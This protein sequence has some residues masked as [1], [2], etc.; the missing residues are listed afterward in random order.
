MSATA[1]TIPHNETSEAKKVR[2]AGA[3]EA[4]GKVLWPDAKGNY[5]PESL[6][7]PEDKIEDEM[8]RKIIGFATP[9]SDEVSRFWNHTMA[10]IGQL[11]GLLEQNYG[12]KRGGRKGNMTFQSFDGL[13]QVSLR[14][15][16][17]IHFGPQ[18]QVA[19]TLVDECLNEWSEGSRPEIQAIVSRAFQVDKEGEV[20]KAALLTLLRFDIDDERWQR[21]MDALRDA[22]RVRGS[23]AYLHFNV[24]DTPDGA[25]RK[26]TIDLASA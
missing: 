6:V 17:L 8:V 21:A 19:K 7:K 12:V 22:I 5:V 26:I 1:A 16:D 10:D 2:P 15:A 3:I 14:M 20:N 4:G 24:R 13:M 23:K 11:V 18:L 25:W 9:L